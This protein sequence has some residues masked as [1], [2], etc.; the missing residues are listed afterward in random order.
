MSC[1]NPVVVVTLTNMNLSPGISY[2]NLFKLRNYISYNEICISNLLNLYYNH[3]SI[4]END[5][6]NNTFN[7]LQHLI[8][9]TTI[10]ILCELL[11]YS[12][13]GNSV[14]TNKEYRN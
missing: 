10:K 3:N 2:Y 11:S 5:F 6:K 4:E 1:S 14:N 12:T 9:R 8:S 13:H 7:Y